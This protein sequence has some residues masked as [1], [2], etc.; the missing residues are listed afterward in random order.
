MQADH[1]VRAAPLDRLARR[2]WARAHALQLYRSRAARMRAHQ[3]CTTFAGE[4]SPCARRARSRAAGACRSSAARAPPNDNPDK[5]MHWC[6]DGRERRGSKWRISPNR[7]SARSCNSQQS[8]R[9]CGK[10][11]GNWYNSNLKGAVF[12]PVTLVPNN[13]CALQYSTIDACAESCQGLG[14]Q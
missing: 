9:L 1:L 10:L 13:L 14:G 4:L 6:A 5:A 12:K 2:M 3:P 8:A 11:F 7:N